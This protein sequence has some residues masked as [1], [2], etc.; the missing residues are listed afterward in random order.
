MNTTTQPKDTD[1][2]EQFMVLR[3]FIGNM[4]KFPLSSW[5]DSN[6]VYLKLV[7]EVAVTASRE[8]INLLLT[9]L[10]LIGYSTYFPEI[11]GEYLYP[12]VIRVI[13]GPTISVVVALSPFAK[14]LVEYDDKSV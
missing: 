13:W 11:S 5:Q 7:S 2:A 12:I 3:K 10:K 14:R 6:G 8:Q 9:G 4:F 1:K